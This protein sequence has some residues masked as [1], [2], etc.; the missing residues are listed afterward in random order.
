[1]LP[2]PPRAARYRI[3]LAHRKVAFV[4]GVSNPEVPDAACCGSARLV[5]G[6]WLVD[7]GS[8]NPLIAAYDSS[9]TRLFALR[10]GSSTFSYR[11]V[12]PVDVRATQLRAAMDELHPRHGS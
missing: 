5:A 8:S 3:D 1:M 2:N 4:E 11:A 10:F 12:P 7:W 9:G 6:E